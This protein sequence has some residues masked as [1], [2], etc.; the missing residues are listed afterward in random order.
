MS[1]RNVFYI[2][3]YHDTEPKSI[4]DIV[5]RAP[6]RKQSHYCTKWCHCGEILFHPSVLSEIARDFK[7]KRLLH[8][9]FHRDTELTS[10]PDMVLRAPRLHVFTVASKSLHAELTARN[11]CS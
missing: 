2:V 11:D 1:Q 4:S 3:F 10:D 5:L 6:R 8:H 7:E 9:F